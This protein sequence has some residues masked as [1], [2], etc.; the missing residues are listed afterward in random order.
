MAA[1]SRRILIHIFLPER[2]E[3]PFLFKGMLQDVDVSI[4]SLDFE[5]VAVRFI[6]LVQ[7]G[8][9]ADYLISQLKLGRFLRSF[10]PFVTLDFDFDRHRRS[11]SS[12]TWSFT[13]KPQSSERIYHRDTEA[14]SLTTKSR[15][16]KVLDN[17]ENVPHNFP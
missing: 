7:E 17:P 9:N 8:G 6:P 1:A 13:T 10:I 3:G 15:R 16:H 11:S 14:Q 12:L 4:S 2:Y 5:I